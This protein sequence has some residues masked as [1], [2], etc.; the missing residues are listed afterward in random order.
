MGFIKDIKLIKQNDIN[1][2]WFTWFNNKHYCFIWEID[3]NNIWWKP[4]FIKE[5][6]CSHMGWLFFQI[7]IGR[8]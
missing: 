4:K 3:F 1:F 2:L 6:K 8:N 7:G 5:S